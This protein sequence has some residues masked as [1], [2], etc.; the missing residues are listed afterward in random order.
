MHNH[1]RWTAVYVR[2]LVVRMRTTKYVITALVQWTKTEIV[3]V[4]ER[5]D[6]RRH[7]YTSGDIS[8]RDVKMVIGKSV[9]RFPTA[10]RFSERKTG[11]RIYCTPRRHDPGNADP[12]RGV[13]PVSRRR[14]WRHVNA[15]CSLDGVSMQLRFF[16]HSNFVD[17]ILIWTWISFVAETLVVLSRLLT[18]IMDCGRGSLVKICGL[19]WMKISNPHTSFIDR[20]W[21]TT[22]DAGVGKQPPGP[23][24]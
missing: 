7:A 17:K 23:P 6:V 11:Y 8:V 2:S 16:W 14:Q 21:D 20:D 13:W 12:D 4:D 18:A 1:R 15:T 9:N 22:H 19:T 24:M 3:P 5:H 10:N